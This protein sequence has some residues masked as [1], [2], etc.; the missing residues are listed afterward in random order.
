MIDIIH[1]GALTV[2]RLFY[3]QE[4][5]TQLC[6]SQ[7]KFLYDFFIHNT[8]NRIRTKYVFVNDL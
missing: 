1:K 2:E 8:T 3:V 5:Q 7:H 6:T 4:M